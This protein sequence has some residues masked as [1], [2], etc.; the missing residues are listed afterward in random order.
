MQ[1]N[2]TVG[3]R[4]RCL[5]KSNGMRQKDVAQS[6][7]VAENTISDWERNRTEPSIE[8]IVQMAFLFQTSTDYLLGKTNS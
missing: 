5:R 1:K 7:H 6:L 2:K 8:S 4:I 3:E